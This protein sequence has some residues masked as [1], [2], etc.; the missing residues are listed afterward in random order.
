MASNTVS[1]L[2]GIV[3]KLDQL[4]NV[5]S[6]LVPS[7]AP[8]CLPV[9]FTLCDLN[10][11]IGPESGTVW[12]SPPFYSHPRGYKMVLCVYHSS[13]F[14][15]AASE[16]VASSCL[17]N[18]SDSNSTASKVIYC[19]QVQLL[20]TELNIQD[21]Y[22]VNIFLIKGEFDDYLRFPM[23][24]S[25]NIHVLGKSGENHCMGMAYNETTPPQ[26]TLPAHSLC[27]DKSHGHWLCATEQLDQFTIYSCLS[28][29]ITS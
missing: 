18:S 15:N 21:G 26:H 23:F 4:Q 1:L 7:N 25:L 11:K 14:N 27:L 2:K 19:D 10:S 8:P 28:F 5:V 9:T 16:P 13:I 12:Q 24:L 20:N 3:E 22:Y 17:S 29:K 6:C